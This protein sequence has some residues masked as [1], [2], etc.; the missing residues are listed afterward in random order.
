MKRADLLTVTPSRHYL[1][2]VLLTTAALALGAVG[3][4][5]NGWFARS[6]GSS[7]VAGWL[8]LAVGVAADLVAL[9]MP[10]TRRW[11]MA[12]RPAGDRAGWLGRLACDVRLRRDGG[13]WFRF[14]QHQRRDADARVTRHAGRHERP[15]RASG[16][17]G[18][19]RPGV[20]RSRREVL[21]RTRSRGR[22]TAPDPRFCDGERRASG[23]PSDR[24][25]D[26]AGRV[27]LSRGMLR[28]RR[29]T[30]PCF[31]SSCWPCCRR[32]VGCC[33][34]SDAILQRLKTSLG[35]GPAR[36]GIFRRKGFLAAARSHDE[37]LRKPYEPK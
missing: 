34:W 31:A 19:P 5:I 1:A 2:P 11:A 33:C 14:H 18:G 29:T 7:D 4:A 13:H 22:R 12:G 21:P 9:V 36:K 16:R 3:I 37:R 6:L 8:F 35:G 15:G 25:S 10:S 23:R 24:R 17:H 27:D 26:Q 28:P 30:L 20:Q 32:S